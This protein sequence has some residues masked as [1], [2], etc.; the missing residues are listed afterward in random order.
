MHPAAN[1]YT[2]E[3]IRASSRLPS[4]SFPQIP[5]FSLVASFVV[6]RTIPIKYTRCDNANFEWNSVKCR[7]SCVDFFSWGAVILRYMYIYIFFV[8]LSR[9]L[10]TI[11]ILFK[12]VE[13][14]NML[15][16]SRTCTHTGKR[17]ARDHLF[18]H[19]TK[20]RIRDAAGYAQSA[21]SD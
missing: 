7:R 17:S 5:P 11:Y 6:T 2:S 8:S 1:N 9:F 14:M 19:T 12:T 15:A 21:R 3:Y 13:R 16:H 10:E 18:F 20:R 4:N